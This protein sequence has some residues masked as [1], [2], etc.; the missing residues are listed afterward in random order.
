MKSLLCGLT[1]VA[2][3]LVVSSCQTS[4]PKFTKSGSAIYSIPAKAGHKTGLLNNYMVNPDCSSGRT[5][6]FKVVTAPANGTVDL[7]RGTVSPS[8]RPGHPQ[9]KCN[10]RKIAAVGA[11]YTPRA[12][13]VGS[14]TVVVSSKAP[15]SDVFSY[16]TLNINVT[17]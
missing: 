9:E 4:D 15:G 5:P 16:V 3:S 2:S 17:K 12:G 10:A 6:D 14:D 7:W 1:L 11:Y 8:F 13:F